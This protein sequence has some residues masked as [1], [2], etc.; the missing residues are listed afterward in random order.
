LIKTKRLDEFKKQFYNTVERVVF[1]KLTVKEM[2]EFS[3]P[4]NYITTMEAFKN[5]PHSTTPL[6]ICMDSSRKQPIPSGKSLKD[7]LMKAPSALVDP[8]Y[9]DPGHKATY[10]GTPSPRIYTSFTSG[11]GWTRTC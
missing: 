3:G 7:C 4:V 10:V 11:C 6:H 9:N 8:F 1:K 2:A 5:E